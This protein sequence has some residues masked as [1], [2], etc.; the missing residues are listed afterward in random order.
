MFCQL[1]SGDHMHA[2]VHGNQS[3]MESIFGSIQ[4]IDMAWIDEKKERLQDAC[5]V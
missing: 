1:F 3:T 5:D 2:C 4:F